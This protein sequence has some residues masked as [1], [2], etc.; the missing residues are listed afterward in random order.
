MS[1][2]YPFCN[3]PY[4][5]NQKISYYAKQSICNTIWILGTDIHAKYLANHPL[6]RENELTNKSSEDLQI[7]EKNEKKRS[8][9][10]GCLL[11]GTT[12]I[13]CPVILYGY[14]KNIQKKYMI[15][16]IIGT[17][18]LFANNIYGFLSGIYNSIKV[19]ICIDKNNHQADVYRAVHALASEFKLIEMADQHNAN[20]DKVSF[21][22]KLDEK[23]QIWNFYK[24][25]LDD[26]K[27]TYVVQNSYYENL[28][29][30]FEV[31]ST[32]T[33]FLKELSLISIMQID[34]LATHPQKMKCVVK[35]FTYER[36]FKKILSEYLM[37][38]N[39][40]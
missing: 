6:L 35:Q 21:I 27:F 10:Y 33:D 8:F 38:K 31:E 36:I 2:P 24:F 30:L 3:Y 15:G 19:N 20:M 5:F 25:Q 40:K 13:L 37:E 12:G 14:H 4:T 28:T 26:D 16:A 29:F 11:A 18:I 34:Y 22:K 9:W 23:K 1:N 39:T 32:A 7:I 17:G